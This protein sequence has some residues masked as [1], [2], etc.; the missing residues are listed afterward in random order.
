MM[1][2][3]IASRSGE[4]ESNAAENQLMRDLAS[5]QSFWLV[6]H[7]DAETVVLLPGTQVANGPAYAACRRISNRLLAL[8]AGESR[9]AMRRR[10]LR[11]VIP[12]QYQISRERFDAT[13]SMAG[14]AA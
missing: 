13:L 14:R 1:D 7:A 5:R 3:V 4:V 11:L 2:Q 6:A 12:M 10:H 8:I 9:R